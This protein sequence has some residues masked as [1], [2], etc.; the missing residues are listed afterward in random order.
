MAQ[1][2][3]G[4]FQKHG[5]RLLKKVRAAELRGTTRVTEVVLSDGSII[6]ADVVVVGIGS[7][8]NVELFEG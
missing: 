3:E 4:K 2:Y 7:K 1:F 6:P 5:V 8:P